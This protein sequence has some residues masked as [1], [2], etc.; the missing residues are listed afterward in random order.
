M[1]VINIEKTYTNI[2]LLKQ[3]KRITFFSFAGSFSFLQIDRFLYGKNHSKAYFDLG[4]VL[5]RV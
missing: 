3:D 4:Y 5:I 1:S 2:E